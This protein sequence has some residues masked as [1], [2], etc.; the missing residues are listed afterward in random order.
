MCIRDSLPTE[1][2]NPEWCVELPEIDVSFI[3]FRCDARGVRVNV[4]AETDSPAFWDGQVQVVTRDTREDI[5]FQVETI[6][7]G[8]TAAITLDNLWIDQRS[9]IH[10][11]IRIDA[12]AIDPRS[13]LAS[14]PLGTISLDWAAACSEHT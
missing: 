7:P 10:N 6:Q 9:L 11:E 2:L 4:T 13:G 12:Q 1:L 5:I 8:Q 3:A 14:G